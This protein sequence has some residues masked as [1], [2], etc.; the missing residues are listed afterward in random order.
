ML[1]GGDESITA[2]EFVAYKMDH[3]YADESRVGRLIAGLVADDGA[4]DADLG[5]AI[6]VLAA[7]DRSARRDSRAAALALRT[8]RLALGDLLDGVAPDQP[9]PKEALRQAAAE[10]KAAFGRLD[11]PWSDAMKLRRGDLALAIDGGPDTLRAVYPASATDTGAWTAAGGD[12]FILYADWSPDGAQ[13]IR[14]IHQFGAATVDVQS[15]HYADQAPLFATEQWKTPP[16]TLDA[17]LAEAT[18]DYR[19][20][21]PESAKK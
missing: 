11:P 20:G 3:L 18:A 7:W 6:A 1:Y 13:A 21:R 12:T 19:P 14:T 2:E 15:P 16:M 5:E 8:A 4:A 9:Q 17:L 10:L